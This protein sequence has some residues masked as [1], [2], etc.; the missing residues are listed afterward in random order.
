MKK[1]SI[2]IALMFSVI[3]STYTAPASAVVPDKNSVVSKNFK[4]IDRS[5]R[6]LR[7]AEGNEEMITALNNIHA[8]ALKNRE[9]VPSFMKAGTKA[10][11]DY[12]QGMDQFIKAITKTIA[13]VNEGK[14]KTGKAA[15]KKLGKIKKKFHKE[16][17]LEDD[18]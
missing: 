2:L 16:F 17:N 3:A 12:Q 14:I 15:V 10:F 11:T 5:L 4:D 13:A 8:I 7:K 18:H 9:E 1:S 6:S